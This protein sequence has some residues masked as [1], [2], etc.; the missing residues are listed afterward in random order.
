MRKL[1]DNSFSRYVSMGIVT[2]LVFYTIFW[3]ALKLYENHFLAVSLAY[4]ISIFVGVFLHSGFSFSFGKPGTYEAF[5]YILVYVTGYFLNLLVLYIGVDVLLFA[6]V[7]VQVVAT[8]VVVMFNYVS[9]KFF[10]FSKA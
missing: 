1:F 3:V 6:A 9:L 8:M 10:V 2:N 7:A 4:P 5:K